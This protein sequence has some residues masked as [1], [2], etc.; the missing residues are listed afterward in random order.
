MKEIIFLNINIGVNDIKPNQN[1]GL[2][3]RSK[4]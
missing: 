4:T 2:R 3:E 1:K